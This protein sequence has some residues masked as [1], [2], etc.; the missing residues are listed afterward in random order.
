MTFP[1][2]RIVGGIG[3]GAIKD[4]ILRGLGQTVLSGIGSLR[5]INA[6]DFMRVNAFPERQLINGIA[7]GA[8]ASTLIL[9]KPVDVWVFDEIEQRFRRKRKNGR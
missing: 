3:P 9:T 5:K 1:A 7:P 2:G 6:S 4:L 8:I